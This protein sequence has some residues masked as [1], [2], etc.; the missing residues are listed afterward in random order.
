MDIEDRTVGAVVEAVDEGC[1]S[2]YFIDS[3][4]VD[5]GEVVIN[6]TRFSIDWLNSDAQT[7]YQLRDILVLGTVHLIGNRSRFG[8]RTIID[9]HCKVQWSVRIG[10]NYLTIYGMIGW[11]IDSFSV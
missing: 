11:Q 10:F 6:A 3:V 5:S 7:L 2:P 1:L 8:H 9:T 4:L